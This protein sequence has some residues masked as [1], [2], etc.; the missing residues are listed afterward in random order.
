[1]NTRSSDL[2]NQIQEFYFRAK[3]P[4]I[5]RGLVVVFF[6]HMTW[7]PLTTVTLIST[8]VIDVVWAKNLDL[9]K[10]CHALKNILIQ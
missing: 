2:S 8:C 10:S 9:E 1:M 3:H 7:P 6:R 5:T 4:P